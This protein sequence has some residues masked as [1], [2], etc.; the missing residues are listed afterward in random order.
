M[1]PSFRK[2]GNLK[3]S[4]APVIGA[5]WLKNTILERRRSSPRITPVRITL[6]TSRRAS[7][8][9]VLTGRPWPPQCSTSEP[10]YSSSKRSGPCQNHSVTLPLYLS[11]NCYIYILFYWHHLSTLA[12]LSTQV[13][14]PRQI[15]AILFFP[16][17]FLL[18]AHHQFIPMN[19]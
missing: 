11:F 18:S 17:S 2:A 13:Q 19:M 9:Y 12:P 7:R 3:F 16:F 14:F 1:S 6:V 15:L 5:T 4:W 10:A 8:P